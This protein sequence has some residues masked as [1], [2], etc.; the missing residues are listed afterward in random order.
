M[1]R[2]LAIYIRNRLEQLQAVAEKEG[3][4]AAATIQDAIGEMDTALDL[5]DEGKGYGVAA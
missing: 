1:N 4:I 3:F 2:T 5:I